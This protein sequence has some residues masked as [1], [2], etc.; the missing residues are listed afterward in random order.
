V[1]NLLTGDERYLD[2]SLGP[3]G[4]VVAAHAR[5][6][7]NDFNCAEYDKKYVP[8]VEFRGDMVYLEGWACLIRSP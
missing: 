5:T 4:A 2:A 8:L 3:V 1:I 6:D 7:R